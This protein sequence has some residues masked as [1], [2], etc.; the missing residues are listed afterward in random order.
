VTLLLSLQLSA[1]SFQLLKSPGGVSHVGSVLTRKQFIILFAQAALEASLTAFVYPFFFAKHYTF[2]SPLTPESHSDSPTRP[3]TNM[4]TVMTKTTT[5][6]LAPPSPSSRQKQFDA[7]AATLTHIPASGAEKKGIR[8]ENLIGFTRV[9][10]G[11]AGPLTIH[12]ASQSGTFFAPFATV[13]PTLVAA[14]SRGC[15]AFQ[16]SALAGLRAEVLSEGMSRAPAFRF[17][18]IDKAVAFLK[19]VPSFEAQFRMD[20]EKTSRYARLQSIKAAI[21]GKTVHVKFVYSCGDA[22]GQNMATLATHAA[23]TAFSRSAAAEE[24]GLVGWQIEGQMSSD[25]KGSWG[26]V[27]TPRGIEV[28]AWGVLGGDSC[29]KVLGLSTKEL[30]RSI[31]TLQDGGIR[32]GQFGSNVNTANVMAAMFIACGQDA[33][34]VFEAGWSQ[35][36]A[37]LD[38]KTHELTLSLY[39]PSLLVGTVGGGTAYATQK[40]ALGLLGCDGVGKKYAFAE[41]V[42]AFC[43]ALDVST[44]SAVGNDTFAASH[45]SLARL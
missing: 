35:L 23:C 9:P 31:M 14:C 37:E 45:Q 8:V 36:T 7:I 42:A 27:F 21:I 29:L 39:I 32:N 28:V 24:A 25:K 16:I 34:G 5:P 11:L 12:G 4:T 6:P 10:L 13:E 41:T 43:L 2:S 15:K 1:F 20:A 44:A 3:T 33:G 26:S 30:Y 40:E 19:L 38:E 18:S 22:A 17:E